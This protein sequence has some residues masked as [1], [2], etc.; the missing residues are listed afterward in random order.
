MQIY[1]ELNPANIYY[2]TRYALLL[3]SLEG[4]VIYSLLFS[5]ILFIFSVWRVVKNG[6]NLKPL[7][8]RGLFIVVVF[9][10][11]M[12]SCGVSKYF[13]CV[14]LFWKMQFFA[15]VCLLFLIFLLLAKGESSHACSLS[16]CL[17]HI[18]YHIFRI[19]LLLC[20]WS[21]SILSI[22]FQI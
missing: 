13:F 14:Q 8:Y 3:D 9:S 6:I 5:E 2:F 4:N 17:E 10:C 12:H 22:Y 11:N 1:L 20:E 19:K 7:I 15:R 18:R 16:V 21:L